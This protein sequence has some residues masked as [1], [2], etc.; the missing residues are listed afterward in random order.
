MKL[1]SLT[2][3]TRFYMFVAFGKTLAYLACL[4]FFVDGI[5]DRSKSPSPDANKG[6]HHGL[7]ELF[8]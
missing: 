3:R 4:Y 1:D 2:P 7:F 5:D 8:E 6:C